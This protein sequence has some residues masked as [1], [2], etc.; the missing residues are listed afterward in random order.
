MEE[1]KFIL[2]NSILIGGLGMLRTFLIYL[3]KANWMKEMML[4]WGIARKVA[5]RFVAGEKL[6]DAILVAKNLNTK[7][8]NATLDQLGED[9]NTPEE[10]RETGE[11]IKEILN[12]IESSGVR[13]GISLKLTQIGLDLSEDLCVEILAGLAIL[14][15]K[16]NNFIR[17]DIED[18]PRVDATM[19]VY[20][21]IQEEYKI[22]NVGMVLQSY[23]YRAEEDLIELLKSNT[24]IRMVKGAYTEPP[25]VAYQK[26]IEVDENFDSLMEI[27]MDAANNNNGP[28][29]SKDGKGPPLPA[30][31]THDPARVE[32]IKEYARLIGLPKDKFEIQMLYGINKGLQDSLAAEGYPVRIYI[33]FG[34]EWYPYFMRR[35]AER[36]AN[37][38]FFLTALF[39]G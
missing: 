5:L 16:Y 37:L 36:P 24:K 12:A 7:G 28:D 29:V 34:Q 32:F 35:L 38:W 18:S 39:R 13:A 25:T 8:M 20:K 2:Q 27:L 14:A 22:N 9:T 30:A 31:G 3:S 17:V 10:A 33:P 23:L 19:R 4:N 21:R 26:K 15:R 6:E 1:K 11:Q